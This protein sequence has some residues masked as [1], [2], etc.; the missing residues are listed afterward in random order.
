VSLVGHVKMV[1][2]GPWS[3]N[4]WDLSFVVVALVV[5]VGLCI[6]R[7]GGAVN[8]DVYMSCVHDFM[9]LSSGNM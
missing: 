4:R 7:D 5:V 6:L 8:R 9:V 1:E 2:R 3:C